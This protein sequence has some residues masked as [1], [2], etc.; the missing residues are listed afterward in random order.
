MD[1]PK[2]HTEVNENEDGVNLMEEEWSDEELE[3]HPRQ[4]TGENLTADK[5]PAGVDPRHSQT[6][7]GLR[8]ST[9]LPKRYL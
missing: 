4:R 7:Y 8:N 1:S 6:C 2:E 5:A 3:V 9:M